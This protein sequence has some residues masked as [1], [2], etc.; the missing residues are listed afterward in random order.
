MQVYGK[1]QE[2]KWLVVCGKSY[3]ISP[4]ARYGINNS[5]FNRNS[6]S[7]HSTLF[8]FVQNWRLFFLACSELFNYNQ[9]NEWI[10]SHYLFEARS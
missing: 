2:T 3:A 9:G 8:F 7:E 6:N 1:G 5:V 10:V 4:P